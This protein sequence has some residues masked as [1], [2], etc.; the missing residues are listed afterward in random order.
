MYRFLLLA[1]LA[2]FQSL[3]QNYTSYFTGS[4]TDVVPTPLGGVCLMGGAAE[5]D[6]AMRWFLRRANGGDVLVLR[7]TGS[8]GYN[9]YLYASLGVPVNSVETIVCNN[10]AASTDPY[11]LRKIQQAEAIW[12]AGGNQQT[13]VSYWRNSPVASAVNQAIRQRRVVVGGTSAGMAIQGKYYF[14]ALN[15]SVTSAAALAN[16]YNSLVT[17]DSAAFIGNGRLTDVLTDTHFDNPDRKGRLAVFLARTYADYRVYARA[18]AC[19]ESTAVCVDANG[20]ATVFGG[21]PARDDNAYFVQANCALAAPAPE[22]CTPGNPLTW[23]LGGQALKVYRIKGNA[24]GSNTFNLNTWQA[25]TGGAWLDWSVAN[26]VFAEQPGPAL[27]CAPLAASKSGEKSAV[28][29]YPNPTTGRAVLAGSGKGAAIT[30][31]GLHDVLGQ[32]AALNYDPSATGELVLHLENLA[33]GV[34]YLTGY[35]GDTPFR[36]IVVVLGQL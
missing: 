34:Y 33:A 14:S 31:L 17:V 36:R 25:G 20:V 6:N 23:H 24:S 9:N 2:P 28:S 11:V 3:G 16:P 22:N 8:N 18:I 21:F 26:G 15:G 27:S 35:E 5:D 19:D 29:L 1:F 32:E 4:T 7:A 13:Y 30:R 12:F 10:A